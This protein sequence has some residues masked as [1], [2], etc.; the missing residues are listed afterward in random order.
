[1]IKGY[2]MVKGE[3]AWKSMRGMEIDPR[4]A[5]LPDGKIMT[6]DVFLRNIVYYHNPKAALFR[7]AKVPYDH[8][9]SDENCVWH[10][11][12]PL[13]VDLGNRTIEGDTWATWK[14]MGFESHS[15]VADPMFVDAEHDDYHLKPDSPC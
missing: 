1:M 4:N 3:P 2:D 15:I 9:R 5:V 14:T 6:G 11:G 13:V 12:E 10:F 7:V 8:Y